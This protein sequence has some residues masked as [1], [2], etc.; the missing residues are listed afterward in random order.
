MGSKH[1]EGANEVFQAQTHLY[2][3]ILNYINSM[4][5]KCAVQLGISDIIH[6]HGKPM[7]LSELVS[8]LQINPT[9]TGCMYRL[10]RMLVQSGIFAETKL[11]DGQNST[12]YAL[13][14]SSSLLV[15][16]NSN[17]LSPFVLAM[18]RPV[19][20]TPYHTLGDWFRSAVPTP[21]EQAHGMTLWEYG[22][23]DPEF[24]SLFNEA[25]SSDS[26]LMN[27]VIKD[28]NQIFE[29]LSSLV[30]VGGGNGSISRI[31]SE[32]FPDIKCT[33]LDLPHVVADLTGSKNLEFIGGDMFLSIPPADALLLKLIFHGWS[34]ENCVNILKKCREAIPSKG[35]V[36]IIDVVINEKKEEHELTET[37]L[38]FDMLMMVA[39]TGRE[40]S[41]K[42]WE[43]LFLEAGFS[44]YK[45]TPLFGLRSLIEVFP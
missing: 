35:K 14:P 30:D 23:Q 18:L 40:R 16:D 4:S 11:N 29:G 17:C 13:T 9:R 27:L 28:C 44:H 38:L 2:N 42:E 21:F 12:A 37:K 32:A 8:A 10:M 26:Q 45:I 39:V 3:H 15:K 5:L 22:V 1:I 36:I 25:M 19:F 41:E 6:N 31:I 20:V 7:T 24:N 33:V 34:D 43:G